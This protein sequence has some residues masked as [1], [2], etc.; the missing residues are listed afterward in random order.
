MTLRH[1]NVTDSDHVQ[2][3]RSRV[4]HEH[5][6][7]VLSK[8]GALRRQAICKKCQPA[9]RQPAGLDALY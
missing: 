9:N 1:S 5:V 6:L 7:E 3:C 8:C 2:N 4:L